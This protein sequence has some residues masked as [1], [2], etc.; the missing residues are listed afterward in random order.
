MCGEFWQPLSAAAQSTAD[1]SVRDVIDVLDAVLEPHLFPAAVRLPWVAHF[2]RQPCRC[3]A[4]QHASALISNPRVRKYHRPPW[5][6]VQFGCDGGGMAITELVVL[7]ASQ[8]Q[9]CE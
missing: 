6:L 7:L 4:R 1:I 5:R 3:L 2:K 8:D 9:A